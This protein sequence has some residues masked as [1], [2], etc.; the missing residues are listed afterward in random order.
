MSTA[1]L[2]IPMFAPIE[3]PSPLK[4]LS[5]LWPHDMAMDLGTAN[6]LIYMRHRG[7]ILNAP[8][9]V[10]V[11][12]KSG[13]VLAI[14]EEAKSIFGKTSEDIRCVR[15]M[16]DGVIADFEMTSLMIDYMLRRVRSRFSIS[17]PRIVIGIPSG[18]TQVEKRAVI[19]AAMNSG[20]REVLLVEEPMAAALGAD[21]PV[22]KP[23]G[24]MVVDIGGGT[25]EVAIISMNGTVY[26]HSVRVAGDEMDEAIQRHV[27]RLYGLQIGIFEA[28]R[29][30]LMIGS[31]LPFRKE[32]TADVFGRDLT[33][34][35]PHKIKLTDEVVRDALH[36]P[37]SAI[38]SSVMA[39]LEHTNPELAHDI[40]E[41]GICLAG[42]GSL[43]KG[44]SER[45]YR[46]TG[47]RF[48]RAQD[49]LSCVI[50]GVGKIVDNFK[51]KK[52][53]CIS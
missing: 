6:T 51:E 27:K 36:E 3:A 45:L 1:G 14:A 10:A 37:I 8:S 20:V 33:S 4:F 17:R 26:S 15:P 23:V 48:Y 41:R 50:R 42:G 38:I 53:L 2:T 22:D 21:L 25:T 18:I 49:P 7:V 11:E 46:E 5:A 30:K 28:E 32:R 40:I 47:I 52:I 16:K 39:A 29:I 44:F 34:G 12:A 13:K 43:L 19:D 24:N 35:L 9:M 31:A